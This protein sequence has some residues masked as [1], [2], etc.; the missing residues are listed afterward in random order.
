M[1]PAPTPVK[2]GELTTA[3]FAIV[4]VPTSQPHWVPTASD[5]ATFKVEP[6]P[7]TVT[8]DVPVNASPMSRKGPAALTTPPLAMVRL[9]GPLPGSPEASPTAIRLVTLSTEPAPVTV[10]CEVP[11][12]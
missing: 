6:A 11:V 9:P 4:S 1:L 3:P 7:V 12:A 8:T 2:T 5:V 10:T